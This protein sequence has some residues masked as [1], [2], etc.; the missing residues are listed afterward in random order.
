MSGCGGGG[1]RTV[2][3][4]GFRAEPGLALPGQVMVSADGETFS[5][6]EPV[7]AEWLTEVTSA[8]DR[9]LAIGLSGGLWES[10]AS[11]TRWEGRSL[12]TGWLDAISAPDAAPGL[13]LASGLG[14]FWKSEDAGG[15]WTRR[16]APGLYFEDFAFLDGATGVGVEGTIVPASGTI[17]WTPDGG[18]SWS[19]RA[20]AE[21][22]LR[23]VAIADPGDGAREIWAAG[24]GGV[25]MVTTDGGLSWRDESGP[26]RWDELPADL[27]DLDFTAD[28]E[29]WLVGTR[30]EARSYR[31]R[32]VAESL[33]WTNGDAGGSYVL[34]GVLAIS[35]DEAYATGYRSFTDRGV[36][37]RTKDGGRTWRVLAETPG[38]FWYSIAGR[39]S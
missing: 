19:A 38:V 13:L 36:V 24:D 26:M 12:Q 33:R 21:S 3:V 25:V 30:G 11:G 5:L 17:W 18:T 6:P 16:D 31:G 2:V 35:R 9:F 37:L 27:T 1:S 23:T 14:S 15:T 29:G 28:G 20:T 22:A 34:Q 39:R 32:E 7:S 8:G 4:V 10:D